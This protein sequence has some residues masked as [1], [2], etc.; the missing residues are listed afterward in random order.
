MVRRIYV[1]AVDEVL[2]EEAVLALENGEVVEVIDKEDFE[3]D[4]F[5][6]VVNLAEGKVFEVGIYRYKVVGEVAYTRRL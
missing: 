6:R 5:S 3:P 1:E 2:N 4:P